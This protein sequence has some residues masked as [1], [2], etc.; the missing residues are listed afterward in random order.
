MVAPPN[1]E[2]GR[3]SLD[4]RKIGRSPDGSVSNRPT[5]DKITTKAGPEN[6]MHAKTFPQTP[7]ILRSER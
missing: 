7:T 5:V 3:Q 4:G 2:T 1:I 6:R